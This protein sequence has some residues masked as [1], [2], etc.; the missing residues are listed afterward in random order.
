MSHPHLH[1]VTN[2]TGNDALT[3]HGWYT[4]QGRL[5]LDQIFTQREVRL[6]KHLQD[7]CREVQSRPAR[8]VRAMLDSGIRGLAAMAM[9]FSTSPPLWGHSS[10]GGKERSG[11]TLVSKLLEVDEHALEWSL[12]T[13][14]IL[15]RSFGIAKV[16]FWA[17]LRYALEAGKTKDTHSLRTRLGEAMEEAVYT[18]L[19][20][21]LCVSFITTPTMGRGV[22]LAAIQHVV[23]LWEGRVGFATNRFCPILRSAWAARCRTPR[24]FGT[25]LGTSEV[26]TLLLQ[27]CDPRFVDWFS[28]K[29]H[30][31]E[32]L[33]AFEEFVFDLPFESIAKVRTKLQEEGRAAVGSDEVARYLGSPGG[34]L[35]PL[36]EDARALYSSFRRRRVQAQYRTSASVPGP[37]R[38]AESYLLEALLVERGKRPEE[39]AGDPGA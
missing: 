35:R 24:A 28:S 30:L 12:P 15:S 33:Q 1:F 31:S 39:G 34:R 18:R 25:M 37:K 10:L 26:V 2:S 27:D 11:A 4:F 6:V 9:Y 21:E 20:E 16:N 8:D 32:E 36:I 13:K 23:D 7:Y 5:S 29:E 14:A 22:R 19:A 3:E 17:S 38:T